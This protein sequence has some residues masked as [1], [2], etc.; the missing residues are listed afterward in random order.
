MTDI[1]TNLPKDIQ[2]HIWGYNPEHREKLN[3]VLDELDAVKNWTYC[4]NDIC[5]KEIHKLDEDTIESSP[6]PLREYYNC[7]FCSEYCESYGTW[8]MCYDYRKSMR[9]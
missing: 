9:R 6:L 5:E 1:L 8:S 7:Y 3:K 2:L 4:D